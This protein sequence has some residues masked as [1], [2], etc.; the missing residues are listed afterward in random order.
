ML[1]STTRLPKVLDAETT[2][3]SLNAD[4]ESL[5]AAVSRPARSRLDRRDSPVGRLEQCDDVLIQPESVDRCPVDL[6]EVGIKHLLHSMS[7][8]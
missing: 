5:R 7:R 4:T 6:R 8:H 2:V 3:K 1:P